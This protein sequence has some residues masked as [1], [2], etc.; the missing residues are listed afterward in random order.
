MRQKHKTGY[1]GLI[2]ILLM[3]FSVFGMGIQ[4]GALAAGENL[5][6]TKF[7]IGIPSP[8]A[9]FFPNYAAKANGYYN[10]EGITESKILAFRGN[11]P[12][13]QALASG[14]IDVAVASL[15]GLV[16]TIK[17]GQPFKGIWAGYTMTQFEWYAQPDKFKSIGETKGASYGVS[18]Y[19]S[20]TDS[21][22]RYILRKA[23]LN[24][25]T[26]VKILQSGQTATIFGALKSG[27]L[28]V[29]ILSI[30]WNFRAAEE[31]MIK[32][33]NQRDD[34]APDY[35][36]HIV[37]AREDFIENNPNLIKAYLRATGKAMDWIKANPD[38]A[39]T[40]LAKELKFKP[41]HCRPTLDYIMDGWYADGRLPEDGMKVFWQIS[42]EIGDVDAPWPTSKW[43]DDRFLKSQ[44]Q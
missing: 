8:S 40:L 44:D 9:S 32:L 27:K 25:E 37:Y 36:T 2:V 6:R 26:D 35:P 39:A 38:D 18:R 42:M 1:M 3:V 29:G 34:I 10:D 20:L 12:T 15:H 13:V 16:N 14:T 5:E 43:M 28:D 4:D 17:S 19:G 33:L 24:P 7:T 30:P 31:G 21:L 11:A 22:T 23:G 41:E